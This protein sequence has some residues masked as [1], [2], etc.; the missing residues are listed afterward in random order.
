MAFERVT[1]LQSIC[2]R[3][4]ALLDDEMF[5]RLPLT[6]LPSSVLGPLDG[7]R[8]EVK[9]F[10]RVHLSIVRIQPQWIRC[11]D[12]FRIDY[13]TTFERCIE[14]VD[15]V[16]AFH[17]AA[18]NALHRRCVTIW[19]SLDEVQQ[20]EI[21]KSSNPVVVAVAWR[22]TSRP[23]ERFHEDACCT[24]ARN[25]WS[26]ALRFWLRLMGDERTERVNAVEEFINDDEEFQHEPHFLPAD[27]DR[28]RLL[29]CLPMIAIKNQQWHLLKQLP[30]DGVSEAFYYFF[31]DGRL[32]L[33]FLRVLAS[34]PQSV[35]A[36]TREIARAL[37][38]WVP[39]MNVELM[40]CEI[41]DDVTLKA[42]VDSL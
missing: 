2:M 22:I 3:V 26:R 11:S 36:K 17:F 23:Y 31:P 5:T 1:S 20:T 42:F 13:A 38:R 41:G 27:D 28:R 19:N 15:P 32:Q 4:L 34:S 40:R 14:A 6:L 24:A 30:V 9:V 25:G 33:P 18:V 12:S 37:V 29:A 8:A 10:I 7:L 39:K 35:R 21:K 16:T